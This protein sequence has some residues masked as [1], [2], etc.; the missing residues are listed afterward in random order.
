M[1]DRILK[2]RASLAGFCVV[3][4]DCSSCGKGL[5]NAEGNAR[6]DAEDMLDDNCVS[7]PS[8]PMSTLVQIAF[9]IA[10][11]A[12]KFD[13]ITVSHI[14][15]VVLSSWKLRQRLLL[16]AYDLEPPVSPPTE[17][18]CWPHPLL[19]PASTT[20][21]SSLSLASASIGKGSRLRST[22]VG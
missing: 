22:H 8:L 15:Q 2:S 5:Q 11:G 10:P 4:K 20:I 13:E 12:F 17:Y 14:A 18:S 16:A 21:G 7:N 1:A 19:L 9:T 3:R 6:H